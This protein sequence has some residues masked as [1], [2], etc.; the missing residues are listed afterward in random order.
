MAEIWQA[1]DTSLERPV[2]IKL[3]DRAHASD[4]EVRRRFLRE[5]HAA[6]RLSG[7]S[8][9]VDVYDVG[10][11]DERPYIVMQFLDGGSLEDSLR[12]H[13]P[14][15][16]AT[17]LDWIDQT[18]AALDSAHA[19]G[20]V[21]RDVK[22]GNLLLDSRGCVRVADFG[23][24]SA[25]GLT[26]FTRVGTILGTAGYLAPEQAR[27]ERATAASDLY[28]LGV[29]A[30]ELLSGRRPF[31]NDSP[32][33][34]LLAHVNERVPSIST[35]TTLPR[36]LDAVFERAL[37]K[38]PEDRF[39]SGAEL[40]ATVRAAVAPEPAPTVRLAPVVV[41]RRAG[42]LPLL[43]ALAAFAIAAVAVAGL[44]TSGGAKRPATTAQT[45]HPTTTAPPAPPNGDALNAQGYTLLQQGNAAAAVPILQQ[46]VQALQGKGP[47][48]P[49]EAYANYNLGVALM[50]LGQCAAAIPYLQRAQQLEPDR[51]EVHQT[52][53]AANHCAAP[54]PPHDNGKHGG[55]KKPH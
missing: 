22:P 42:W 17:A 15:P 28:A 43:L 34:E 53:D 9:I 40:A 8:N 27:G 37:A 21:H 49:S 44:L 38:R 33:A 10:E 55:E 39:S 26:S 7:E 12:A 45:T 19:A 20:V 5:A 3:L 54:P 41:R 48:D 6:A 47:A 11:W 16:T 52:L 23:I 35:G 25:T 51:Q 31:A 4:D 24:A 13:G 50:Q 14:P 2:A 18:A 29:V 1:L 32:A 30:Y 36:E 46:A